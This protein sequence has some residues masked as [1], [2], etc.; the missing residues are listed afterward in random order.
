MQ[1]YLKT[2]DPAAPVLR[3]WAENFRRWDDEGGYHRL[4][5]EAFHTEVC[6]R[7][8]R[9]AAHACVELEDVARRDLGLAHFVDPCGPREC[10]ERQAC[11]AAHVGE[12]YSRPFE[13]ID[14]E[15]SRRWSLLALVLREIVPRLGRGLG[16]P[17]SPIPL[18]TALELVERVTIDGPVKSAANK[19]PWDDKIRANLQFWVTRR[20]WPRWRDWCL[21]AS[22]CRP[23]SGSSFV[24]AYHR[25]YEALRSIEER[26]RPRVTLREMLRSKADP[27]LVVDPRV[28]ATGRRFPPKLRWPPIELPP[29]WPDREELKT[30]YDFAI[31]ALAHTYGM[32]EARS[33]SMRVRRVKETLA[34]TQHEL[35]LARTWGAYRRWLSTTPEALHEL[36]HRLGLPVAAS[37]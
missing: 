14:R 35:A 29:D 7:I 16:W 28:D 11:P 24:D 32:E 5:A 15:G 19:R 36:E 23:S 2:V 20:F 13:G 31:A 3:A 21:D 27:V 34:A 4:Q 33:T 37:R 1:P 6:A 30:P 8:A 18:G 12:P 22:W 10:L 9:R 17:P 26:G 25:T